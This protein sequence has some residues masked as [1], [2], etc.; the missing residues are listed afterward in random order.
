[1]T[2]FTIK[3]API[4]HNAM[5]GN[6]DCML[7]AYLR[8]HFQSIIEDEYMRDKKERQEEDFDNLNSSRALTDGTSDKLSKLVEIADINFGNSNNWD[9][10]YLRK[11]NKLRH[12]YITLNAKH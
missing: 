2:D 9:L 11:L 10:G 1:M 4:P 7:R 8:T 6:E 5:Y 12:D 3:V